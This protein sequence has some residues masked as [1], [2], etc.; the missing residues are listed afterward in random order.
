MGRASARQVDTQVD[1]RVS[2]RINMR[3]IMLFCQTIREIFLN[4]AWPTTADALDACVQVIDLSWKLLQ[5]MR[6]ALAG[7]PVTCAV[8][9]QQ[10]IGLIFGG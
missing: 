10:V 4:L 8:N 1:M 9:D 2:M 7:A 6:R 3:I 5:F